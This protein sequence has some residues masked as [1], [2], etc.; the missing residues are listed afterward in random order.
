MRAR[1][2]L[3]EEK[4]NRRGRELEREKVYVTRARTRERKRERRELKGCKRRTALM[5]EID[6]MESIGESKRKRETGMRTATDR[7]TRWT[8]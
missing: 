6:D 7:C 2:L 3:D 4:R 1:A 5:I 8:R